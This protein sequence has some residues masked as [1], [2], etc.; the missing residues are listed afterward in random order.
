MI[1]STHSGLIPQAI[2]SLI[3]V[4]V[5]FG[6]GTQESAPL[7]LP[8]GVL[9]PYTI[10]VGFSLITKPFICREIVVV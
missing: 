2:A 6:A 4:A 10:T 3:R 9:L 1:S 5:S 7:N 8:I